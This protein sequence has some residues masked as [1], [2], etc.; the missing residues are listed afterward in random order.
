MNQWIYD[1]YISGASAEMYVMLGTA[2]FV[3]ALLYGFYYAWKMEIPLWK[4]LILFAVLYLAIEGLMTGIFALLTTLQR[5]DILKVQTVTSSLVRIFTIIPL[6]S[7]ILGPVLRLKR[8]LVCDVM[9]VFLQLRVA[10]AQISCVFGGCCRGYECSWGIYVAQIDAY[11]LPVP[12]IE[13][14]LSLIVFFYM[15]R[16]SANR[17]YVS[18]GKLYPIMLV[19]FGVVRFVCEMLRDREKIVLCF[20]ALA[21]HSLFLCVVGAVWLLVAKAVGKRKTIF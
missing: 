6:L 8:G 17:L 16:R 21:L 20:S 13:T 12:I 3:V 7:L 18:D 11:C 19:L 5:L 10:L 14:V 4:T 15:V 2:G 1:V 9:A